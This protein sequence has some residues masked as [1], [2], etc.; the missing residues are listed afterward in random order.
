MSQIFIKLPSGITA[1]VD[2]ENGVTTWND[3]INK[4]AIRYGYHHIIVNHILVTRNGEEAEKFVSDEKFNVMAQE[5][6][7][8]VPFYGETP[9]QPAAPAP[10]SAVAAYAPVSATD[11]GAGAG[12]VSATSGSRLTRSRG[13]ADAGGGDE[14]DDGTG[15]GAG[16]GAGAGASGSTLSNALSVAFS[17][18]NKAMNYLIEELLDSNDPGRLEVGIQLAE[19][20]RKMVNNS[21]QS[22]GGLEYKYKKYKQKYILLK[23]KL[24]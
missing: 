16:A 15:E 18:G 20:K 5:I 22:G 3:V 14:Y 6:I 21:S 4:I 1:T 10:G 11:D 9:A 17:D 7:H 19:I 13:A 23:E 24:K 12:R 2:Y 8:A